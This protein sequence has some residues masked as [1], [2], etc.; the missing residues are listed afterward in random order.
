MAKPD[1]GLEDPRSTVFGSDGIFW[2]TNGPKLRSL[3]K[4]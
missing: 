4:T 1:L 3:A 2:D